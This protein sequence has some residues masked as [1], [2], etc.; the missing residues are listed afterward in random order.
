MKRGD[1]YQGPGIE[2]AFVVVPAVA[3]VALIST[4]GVA[5][6]DRPLHGILVG[7]AGFLTGLAAWLGLWELFARLHPR[8][9]RGV[10]NSVKWLAVVCGPPVLA[11]VAVALLAGRLRAG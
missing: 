6:I 9:S 2:T 3:L 8:F 10:G 5:A 11:L 4:I 7:C 1:V